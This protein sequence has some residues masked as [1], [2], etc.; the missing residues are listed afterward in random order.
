MNLVHVLSAGIKKPG[1]EEEIPCKGK[2]L[3]LFRGS[4]SKTL[5]LYSG[6]LEEKLGK[7]LH[8]LKHK[9]KSEETLESG[10]LDGK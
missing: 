2:N 3:M 4:P 6:T 10:Q 8:H 9:G 1:E 5:I 7:C